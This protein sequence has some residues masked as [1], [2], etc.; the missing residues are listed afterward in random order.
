MRRFPRSERSRRV[1]WSTTCSAAATQRCRNFT[2]RLAATRRRTKTGRSF[3]ARSTV[4]LHP[5]YTATGTRSLRRP[6][7]FANSRN[8]ASKSSANAK[9]YASPATVSGSWHGP[10]HHF[11]SPTPWPV[12]A[13]SIAS[14]DIPTLAGP[15]SRSSPASTARHRSP[16]NHFVPALVDEGRP[17]RTSHTTT[18]TD[19]PRSALHALDGRP[20]RHCP[21][22][23]TNA[24]APKRAARSPFPGSRAPLAPNRRLTARVISITLCPIRAASSTIRFSVATDLIAECRPSS[25]FIYISAQLYRGIGI[26]NGPSDK[27]CSAPGGMR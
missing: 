12:A 10:R 15:V 7:R 4:E 13:N 1:M 20:R 25:I 18:A 19:T 9:T 5:C 14:A 21:A 22:S 3:C 11:A 17:P 2:R 24:A 16:S 27:S 6:V 8:C 26:Q 23:P